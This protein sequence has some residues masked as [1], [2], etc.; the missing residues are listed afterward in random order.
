MPLFARIVIAVGLLLLIVS[1]LPELPGI[2]QNRNLDYFSLGIAF[3]L[4]SF[5][6]YMSA[7]K[8]DYAL[9]ICGLTHKRTWL[10]KV[11]FIGFF[12]N[13]C[14]PSNIGGDV[15]RVSKT[16]LPQESLSAPLTA[17]VIDRAVG[18]GALLSLG[19]FA[20]LILLIS[21]RSAVI[22]A[23]L[24]ISGTL[25]LCWLSYKFRRVPMLSKE[26]FLK[27]QFIL[28]LI[29]TTG[30][31]RKNRRLLPKIVLWNFAFQAISLVIIYHLFLFFE[32]P[33]S[34]LLAAVYATAAGVAGAIPISINGLGVVESAYI[35]VTTIPAAKTPAAIA[36]AVSFAYRIIS[37][38]HMLVGALLFIFQRPPR[39]E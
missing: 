5:H 1:F 16:R 15:Y 11:I 39:S 12:F 14:L 10:L 18:L 28:D 17:V 9:Q 4:A 27:R 34:L 33:T 23:L 8:W 25:A 26:F 29:N 35:L 2:F 30:V 6:F 20:I 13:Q 31:I 21:F 3:I 37:I 24:I 7:I 32:E 19:L 36:V 22:L 38:P